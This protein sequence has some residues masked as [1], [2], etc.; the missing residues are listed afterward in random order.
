M[1]CLDTLFHWTLITTGSLAHGL[2]PFLPQLLTSSLSHL[3]I[4]R[5]TRLG[6]LHLLRLW[7]LHLLCR[8][9]IWCLCRLLWLWR[10]F[11]FKLLRRVTSS[12][13]FTTRGKTR[14][15]VVRKARHML[16]VFMVMK[17][18]GFCDGSCPFGGTL[19]ICWRC[20]V[21]RA[22]KV[23]RWGRQ[24]FCQKSGCKRPCVN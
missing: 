21:R 18:G 6:C 15:T 5:F 20:G 3:H 24:S 22:G 13:E 19:L 12:A 9:W 2:S 10:L 11:A 16:T 4:L 1:T 17:L 8:R 23:S 14:T 7:C